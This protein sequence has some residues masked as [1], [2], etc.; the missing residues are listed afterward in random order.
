M[1][2]LGLLLQENLNPTVIEGHYFWGRK[3]NH[4]ALKHA[5]LAYAVVK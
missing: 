2:D 4:H 3:D 5:H 1:A